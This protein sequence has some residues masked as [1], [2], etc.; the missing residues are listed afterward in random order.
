MKEDVGMSK[1][2]MYANMVGMVLT[3][4]VNMDPKLNKPL[5]YNPT[6][7]S[8]A[9]CILLYSSVQ[10]R[11][12]SSEKGGDKSLNCLKIG[13]QRAILMHFGVFKR[14]HNNI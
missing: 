5:P 9:L 8:T 11:T 4:E 3:Q 7:V 6:Y 14:A 12:Q 10:A 1:L 2:K 13:A